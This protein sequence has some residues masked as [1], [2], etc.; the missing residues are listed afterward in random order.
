MSSRSS[1]DGYSHRPLW[2]APS[3]TPSSYRPISA[4]KTKALGGVTVICCAI[5][6]ATGM[7]TQAQ[8]SDPIIARGYAVSGSHGAVSAGGSTATNV[9]LDILLAGG[10]AFDAA[11]ATILALTET[12]SGNVHFGGEVPIV[13]YDAGGE[14]VKV[15][16]GQGVAP[17]LATLDYFQGIGGIPGASGGIKNA[18]VPALPLAVMTLVKDHGTMTFEQIASPARALFAEH[19]GWK[20]DMARTLGRMIQADVDAR[21]AGG[22]REAGLRAARDIFYSGDIANEMVSWIST[23]GGLI[24]WSDLA[25]FA[26]PWS[27]YED[28][29]GIDYKGSRVYK[30]GTWT[31]GPFLLETLEILEDMNVA[32][33]GHNSADYTHVVIEAM[34]LGLADRD[35]YYGDPDFV[36]VPLQGLLSEDYAELRRGLINMNSAS[37]EIRPGDPRTP[38]ALLD[39][40]PAY[41]EGLEGPVNDTST[42]ITADRWGNV[43]VATPSGW[44]GTL[45]GNRTGVY[46]NSRLI[47]FNTWTGHPNAIAPGKRPRITLTPTLVLE[48]GLPEIGISVA[49]GDAQDQAALQVFL[50]LVEFGL[51]AGD[52]VKTSSYPRFGTDHLTGSFSQPSP[53]LGSLKLNSSVPSAVRNA[54]TSR[55]HSISSTGAYGSTSVM[56][57]DHVTG[58][59]HAAGDQSA[60]RYAAAFSLPIANNP[61]TAYSQSVALDE[62]TQVGIVLTGT[63]PDGDPVT[64]QVVSGPSNGSLSGAAPNL[65]YTP[66]PDY[67]GLD[68]FAFRTSDG[69]L[70]STPATVSISVTPVNDDPLT[71]SQLLETEVDT[72]LA[73]TLIATDPDGD[74]LT[75][76]IYEWPQWGTL[77]GDAPDDLVYT[78][79]PGFIGADRFQYS[80]TDGKGFDE[81]RITIDVTPENIPPV[82]LA[83][84]KSTPEG[85]PLTF[86]LEGEDPDGPDVE[87]LTYEL[88]TPPAN[89]S[90]TVLTPDGKQLTYTPN[91]NF[92]GQDSFTY[93]A[94]DGKDFSNPATVTISVDESGPLLV[95]ADDFETNRGWVTNPDLT[96]TATSGLWERGNPQNTSSSGPKQ[97][98]TTT[99]G[100]YDLV[101]GAA[102]GS[103]AGSNDLDGG[104]TSIRSP[105]IA[106][107]TGRDLSLSFSYYF[108]HANNSSSADFLR[109]RVVGNTT[110]TLLE[111]RGA[112]ND[113]DA[114]WESATVS[115]N[116]LAG[117]SVYLLIE[118]ADASSA[119]LVEAAI[120][121]LSIVAA[122][123]AR[124]ILTA[125]FDIGED[126]FAY[127]DDTFRGTSKPAY[128]SGD[129]SAT[130]GDV[131]GRLRVKLGGLDNATINGMSGGWRTSFSLNQPQ[132]VIVSVRYNLT[133]S[134]EYESDEYSDALLSVDG[135]LYGQGGDSLARITGDG[136]GGSARTT[137]WQSVQVDLG[138]LSAG[139]HTL[140][141]GG[142]NNKKTYN[143]ES[144]DLLIDRL[145]VDAY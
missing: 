112:G 30:A 13:F 24:Q 33:Y 78:P 43:V 102:A 70:T 145:R 128:A 88:L 110:V 29:V 113:D 44:G 96:D 137:G 127:A 119:S 19:T 95:F 94:D 10:N 117:Q 11:A 77:T 115:L 98:G 40:R 18:A 32:S 93:R 26:E 21:A 71:E 2:S 111:E 64:F 129:W 92:I 6:A 34:K 53:K 121:D 28:P 103:S 124:P 122:A 67:F 89:G 45:V 125:D 36:N 27:R 81:A 52:S 114:V 100:S 69:K 20:A 50:N 83:L 135:V 3:P 61:P 90:L 39:G 101:T 23:N 97:L 58:L 79:A 74:P 49:G 75:Y 4:P 15:L 144:T 14:E 132:R 42:C 140:A 12:D 38:L 68:S 116:Q 108:A 59:I 141:I 85:T 16:S 143:D 47:S 25:D 7:S 133:Q 109:V 84:A 54:L 131:G 123:P 104:L 105:L 80:V 1:G 136:N 9:G 134:S 126:G 57:L 56:V 76:V 62:D 87:V 142:Y 31:Q 86:A 120:D 139:S 107:P 82:A 63:D 35:T 91:A 130:G 66:N 65:A 99:S 48:N 8:T 55:G 118:A 51:G 22:N 106:L 73:I 138:V 46:M 41:P 60:S 5:L 72:P 37:R 17:K